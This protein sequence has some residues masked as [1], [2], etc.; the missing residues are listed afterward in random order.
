MKISFIGYGNMAKAIA[1]HWVNRPS[2][3]IFGASPTLLSGQIIDDVHTHSN[4]LEVAKDADIIVIATKPNQAGFVLNEIRDSLKKETIIISVCAGIGLSHLEKYAPPFQPIITAMPNLPIEVGFGATALMAN[5]YVEEDQK[6]LI[7]ELFKTSGITV[8]VNDNESMWALTA[9]SGSG[10]A[11]V[12]LFLE[13][14]VK[15]AHALN[16][17]TSTAYQFAKQTLKGTL[18]LLEKTGYTP[19]ILRKKITSPNGTTAK[20]LGILSENHF[21]TLIERAIQAAFDRAFELSEEKEK[22]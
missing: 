13:S 2:L 1:K 19:D 17:P 16:I 8:W 18:A 11:Y 22:K 21:E 9:L 7:E 4:N 10:P 15:G 14:L 3:Q 6:N 12:C 5:Q 20:A